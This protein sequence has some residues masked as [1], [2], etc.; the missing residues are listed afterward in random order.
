[1]KKMMMTFAAVFC[2][3]ITVSVF[4]ACG[5]DDSEQK[6][7]K[8]VA[9]GVEYMFSVTSQDL[10]K[11]VNFTIEYYD[12]EGK[13]QSEQMVTELWTDTIQTKLPGKL[14]VRVKLQLKDGA[15]PASM[16]NFNISYFFRYQAYVLTADGKKKTDD[17]NAAQPK[18]TIKGSDVPRWIEENPIIKA[19]SF[20][21][22]FDA[23]GNYINTG[24]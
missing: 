13:V 7:D 23:D 22:S 8:P 18:R 16:E 17:L 20:G 1:M 4:S 2:C 9:C 6:T 24:F 11:N 10:F 3:A 12:A 19:A 5:D 14:G 21:Y 15:D